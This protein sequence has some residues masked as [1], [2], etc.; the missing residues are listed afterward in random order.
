MKKRPEFERV[1]KNMWEGVGGGKGKGK[2]KNA[3]FV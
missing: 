1:G 2:Q 3:N